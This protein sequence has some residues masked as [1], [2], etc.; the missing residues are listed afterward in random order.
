MCVSPSPEL[1]AVQLVPPFVVRKTPSP[2]L[3]ANI[4]LPLATREVM[5]AFASIPELTSVQVLPLSEDL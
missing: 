4:A 1:T 2:L 3:P 5:M